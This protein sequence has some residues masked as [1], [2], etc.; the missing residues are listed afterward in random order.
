MH[1]PVSGVLLQKYT[2][3]ARLAFIGKL[4]HIYGSVVSK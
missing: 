1:C 4:L 2:R 3:A